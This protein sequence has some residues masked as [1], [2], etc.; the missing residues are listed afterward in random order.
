[1]TV[2]D[3]IEELA[4]EKNS[5]NMI[6]D[7]LR[8]LTYRQLFEHIKHSQSILKMLGYVSGDIVIL[9]T[10]KQLDF[11]ILFLSFLSIECWVIPV[12]PDLTEYEIEKIVK[13]AGAKIVNINLFDHLKINCQN[14]QTGFI[15]PKEGKS[16]IYHLTSGT[17]GMPKLCIRTLEGLTREG[18]SFRSTLKLTPKD[19]IFG[20]APLYH[21][22]ALGAVLM[23]ALVSGSSIY[24]SDEFIPRKVLRTI[25]ENR[26]TIA[27]LIPTMVRALCNVFS[28]NVF[29]ISSVRIALVGAGAITE[30]IYRG[31]MEKYGIILMSN[32]GSTETGGIISRLEPLPSTS[33]GKPM[34]GVEIKLCNDKGEIISQGEG[35]IWV[36]CGSMLIGYYGE[37]EKLFDEQGFF[38][39]GDIAIQDKDNN[40]FI[41]G[42]KKLL[43]NVGGK[44]VNPF[45]VEEVLQSFP[46][47]KECVVVGKTD[48][49]G[50]EYV[51]AF[52]VGKD[53]DEISLRK[54]CIEKLSRYKIPSVIEFR[55]CIPRNNLGKIKRE[56]LANG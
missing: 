19:K 24:I 6:S 35:E 16:G 13:L 18:L 51:K 28:R 55:G 37:N 9:R 17:T 4:A 52:V 20:V 2:F 42:R 36:K 48:I 27:I 8:G 30:D 11:I 49:N 32:Y 50:V 26:I 31:F 7:G 41:K 10:K 56:E 1:M 14:E 33:I 5:R 53:V 25:H 3:F 54:Y 40:V 38:P 21:S 43:I 12:S 15:K 29:D 45:E 34:D 44:K 22:Y 39:M 23:A 47:V 46:G